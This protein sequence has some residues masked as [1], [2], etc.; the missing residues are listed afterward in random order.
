MRLDYILAS[1]PLAARAVSCRVLDAH[2]SDHFP[3]LAEFDLASGYPNGVG[4]PAP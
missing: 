3:V 2:A 4:S 1:G